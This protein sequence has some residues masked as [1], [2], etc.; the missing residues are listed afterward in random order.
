[1]QVS[2]REVHEAYCTRRTAKEGPKDKGRVP[3]ID[4][5]MRLDAC[6][7]CGATPAGGI[8]RVD[9]DGTYDDPGNKR[10]ACA[11]CNIMKSCVPLQHF[12]SQVARIRHGENRA[13]W[14]A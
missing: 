5:P 8:D 3:A 12:L 10:A 11:T 9:S 2:A 4:D 1:M 6:Y 14:F 13:M 7:L